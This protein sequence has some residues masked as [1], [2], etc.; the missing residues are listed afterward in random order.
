MSSKPPKSFA[1]PA[2]TEP[3]S[4]LRYSIEFY[5]AALAAD[6]AGPERKLEDDTNFPSRP[7]ATL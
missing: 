5:A 2:R 6:A 3:I 4:M 7:R 1:D